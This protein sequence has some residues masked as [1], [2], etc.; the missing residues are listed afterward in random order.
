MMEG[1]FRFFRKRKY[2]KAAGYQYEIGQF[3]LD[4]FE[5]RVG[6]GVGLKAKILDILTNMLLFHDGD[7]M[8]PELEALASKCMEGVETEE[9]CLVY[10][11]KYILVKQRPLAAL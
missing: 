1:E 6:H 9:R 5:A 2:N 7:R 4:L 8:T 10:I 11:A 3:L